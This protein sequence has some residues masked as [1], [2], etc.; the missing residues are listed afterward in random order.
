MEKR[1]Q[2]FVSS[3]FADLQE[4]RQ[5]VIQA[6][7]EMD[8]IHAGMELFP[9][10]DE[11]QW[12][13]IKRIIDD[14]DY[15]LLII[16]G[17]Y[18]SVTT[19]GVSYTEMEYDYAVERGLKVVVL[20][21]ESPDELPASK[22][23]MDAEAREKL[24]AFRDKVAIGRLVKFW[25]RSDQLPGLVALSLSKTIKTYPAVGWV[26]ADKA[27][28]AELLRQINELRQENDALRKQAAS[29]PN[30]AVVPIE[31]LAQGDDVVSVSGESSPGKSYS[32]KQWEAET[33][34]NELF[35][36]LGPDLCQYQGEYFCQKIIAEYLSNKVKAGS[37][38]PKLDDHSKKIIKIQFIA[39][40]LIKVDDLPLKSGGFGQFWKIT[41][42][43]KNALMQ[44][45]SIKRDT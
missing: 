36:V 15:Y 31:T 18:G 26:R 14:C 41:D 11:E 37:Y 9:A 24:T 23:E 30:Q 43:G 27:D 2:I 19:E 34:W 38:L 13:F 45:M 7:M 22:V 44:V 3:T 39:L 35:F 16:G 8:C 28:S 40:G 25:N 32:H 21:H 12:E 20:L 4:E 33:T 1:Y 42:A 10:A 29:Q 5:Q 17:R 6:L